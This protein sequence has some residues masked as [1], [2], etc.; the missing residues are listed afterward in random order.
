MFYSSI[1]YKLYNNKDLYFGV[2]KHFFTVIKHL[3][4]RSYVNL[5]VDTLHKTLVIC[6]KPDAAKKIAKALKEN[7][8]VETEY[9]KVKIFSFENHNQLYI[10]CSTLGH[11][12]SVGDPSQKRHCYPTFDLEWF[13]TNFN[14]NGNYVSNRISVIK[15]IAK[16]ADTFINACDFDIEGETIC[17]NILKYAC[18]EKQN[19]AL[20]AKFS[21]LTNSELKAAFRNAT[22]DLDHG[23]ARAGR[24]RH[25]VDFIYGIN[26]SRALSESYHLVNKRYKVISIGRVQGPTLTY[27]VERESQIGTFVPTPFWHL[28]TLLDKDGIKLTAEYEKKPVLNVSEVL[29]ISSECRGKNCFVSKVSRSVFRQ[30]PPPPFNIGDLQKEAYR[31]F[32]CSPSNTLK[33]AESLYLKAM[34]SYPRTSSQKL[35]LSI[36]YRKIIGGL[37]RNKMYQKEADEILKGKMT[38]YQG[39]KDDTAHPAIYPTGEYPE[40]TLKPIERKL[41]DLIV[42]RFFTAFGD[43]ALK[44]SLSANLSIGRY[45]FRISGRCILEEG[46]LRYYRKYTCMDNKSLPKLVEGEN[47]TLVD[48]VSLEKFVQPPPR[49]NQSSLLEK[50]ENEEIGTKATRADII[51]TLYDRGYLEGHTIKATEMAFSVVETMKKF[52]PCVTSTK[53]TRRIEEDLK[54]IET[55]KIHEDQVIEK[56]AEQTC[57]SLYAIKEAEEEI[58]KKMMQA[59]IKTRRE[60]NFLGIC[61]ICK[62]GVLSIIRSRKTRKRFVG[63]SN[64]PRGC[65]AS[66][67]LPQ[68][69]SI[70][71]MNKTCYTCGWPIIYVRNSKIRWKLC[72]NISCESKK[73]KGEMNELPAVQQRKGSKKD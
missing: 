59:V 27:I 7:D 12:Y 28:Y 72:V 71:S 67:P 4:C 43:F 70:K 17:Y 60:K 26:L 42:K 68:K 22:S 24:T 23:L 29:K 10:I 46:W 32:R 57:E 63:C 50:M 47:L 31:I 21:A 9:N 54:N 51:Q 19:I 20:R 41:Y 14:K 33:I 16:K 1:G 48:L 35:P 73:K 58:G 44:E 66:S 65:R 6:E 49:Y 18:G 61:P 3:F 39:S 62:I 53:M 45:I 55:G 40:R 37:R 38:P 36:N 64:Y 52:S 34:I 15:K 5:S 30:S 2:K 25:I 56:A 13:P 8:I 69:G 11:L